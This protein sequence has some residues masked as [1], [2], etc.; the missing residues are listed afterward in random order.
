MAA[1]RSRSAPGLVKTLLYALLRAP[2]PLTLIRGGRIY[3]AAAH[4]F[5]VGD[6]LLDGARIAAVG[7]VDAAAR[8]GAAVVDAGGAYVSAGFIDSHTHIFDH[9]LFR[10]GRLAADRIG[11]QQGVACCVDAGSFGATTVD[12]FPRFV[13]E[14]QQTRAYAFINIGSPG[15]PNV[16]GG[17]TSRPDLCDLP[18]VVKAFDRHGD[19]LLG[20]K[21]LASASHTESFGEQAVKMAIKAAALVDLPVMLHIGNAPPVIDDVLDMLRPGDIVTHV[22]HGK[23][24]GVLTYKDRVLPAFRAAIERGV[25]ADIGHGQSSFSFRTCELALA[26]G[27]PVHAISSDLHAGNVNKYA[28]SLARTMTKLLALGLSLADVVRAVTVTP[29]HMLHLDTRGFGT[30]APG[31]PAHVTLFDV[32][33]EP[34]EIEDAQ[35]DKRIAQQ[36]IQP[37]GVFVNGAWHACTAGL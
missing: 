10:T 6:V 32:L 21:V 23:V 24:G 26:Q 36:W 5:A 28:F 27:M 18:G 33:D 25:F 8:T 7:A 3:D 20:V 31:A 2:M 29:A 15:L 1:E 19:W 34:H 11:V 37:R 4:A 14:T 30:L 12:A 22:Y 17:H 13:H 16:G 35:R 9:P